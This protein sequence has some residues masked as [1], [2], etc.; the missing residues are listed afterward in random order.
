MQYLTAYGAL[1]WL[2]QVAKGDFVVIT[3]ASSS[4]GIAAVEM[5]KA[6]D[7][8]LVQFCDSFCLLTHDLANRIRE[9]T[10]SWYVP[11]AKRAHVHPGVSTSQE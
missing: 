11:N 5:V 8:P 4:V 9:R 2:G 6:T 7:K 1:I 3:V 10:V